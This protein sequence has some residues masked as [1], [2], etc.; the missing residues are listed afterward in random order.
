MGVKMDLWNTARNFIEGECDMV[1]LGVIGLCVRPSDGALLMAQHTWDPYHNGSTWKF[2][3]G[4]VEPGEL[5][6]DA[7]RREWREELG[8]GFTVLGLVGVS[9][10]AE[11]DRTHILY[12]F[13]GTC[14]WRKIQVDHQELARFGWVTRRRLAVLKAHHQLLSPRDYFLSQ[15]LLEGGNTERIK[16][17]DYLAPQDD[18]EG[19]QR[20]AFYIAGYA[21]QDGEWV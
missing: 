3:G 14:D 8:V 16:V 7:M 6:E 15:Y 12:L 9:H 5:P 18:R 1:D 4:G 20:T 13:D 17:S 10:R 21:H 11:S 2:V 19:I